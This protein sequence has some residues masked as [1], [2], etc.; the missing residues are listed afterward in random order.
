MDI[1]ILTNF[2]FMAVIAAT[3]LLFGTLGE[4]LTQKSGSINLGVEGMMFMGASIGL[5]ASYF[6]EFYAGDGTIGYVALGLAV[7]FGFLAGALGGFIYSVL[8][9]TF[10]ANQNVTGLAL[11]IFG[12]GVGNLVG[13][14]LSTHAQG[15]TSST[16]ATRRVVANVGIPILRDIPILGRMLFSYNIM[17]YFVIVVAILLMWFFNKTRVGLNLRAVGENPATADAVGINV[18][19]YKY[20]AAS[21]GG[22]ICGLGGMV[23]SMVDNSGT[24]V[25][26]CVAG[27]GW[28]AVALVIFAAWKP[29]RAI[30]GAVLF[31]G[32]SVL[33]LYFPI[34]GVPAQ[35]YDIVPYAA[36]ILALV[37]TSIRRSKEN[38]QPKACGTNYF[39]EER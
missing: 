33:R 20:I 14:L 18:T 4:I 29:S 27:R 25:F 12:I 23:I 7:I 2:F 17:V 38:A 28:I 10:R 39:R 3:P 8:T 5:S 36:T 16:E 24:W 35:V 6:Y 13:D 1:D 31:G 15:F 26:N 21:I 30:F 9:V 34:E 22:G 32:L 19:R 37:L 11:T